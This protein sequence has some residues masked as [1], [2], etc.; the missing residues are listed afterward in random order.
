MLATDPRDAGCD[1]TFAL[2]RAYASTPRPRCIAPGGARR[3]P[4][5]VTRPGNGVLVDLCGDH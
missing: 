5:A 4:P 2:I 1:E 3:P